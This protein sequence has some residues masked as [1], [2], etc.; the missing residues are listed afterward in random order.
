[1][2]KEWSEHGRRKLSVQMTTATDSIQ[3]IKDHSAEAN[4]EKGMVR[5]DL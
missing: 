4:K 2:E 5:V 3:E 1:M